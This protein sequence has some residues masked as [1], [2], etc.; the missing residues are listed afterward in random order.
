MALTR[1]S[2]QNVILAITIAEVPRVTRLVRSLGLSLREQPFVEAARAAGTRNWRILLASHPAQHDRAAD[3]PGDLYLRVRHH[4]RSDPELS[5][6]RYP[7][8]D[9]QAGA[10]SSPKGR[11]VFLVAAYII[12]IPSVFLSITVLAINLFGDGLRDALDPAVGARPVTVV[13]TDSAHSTTAA[14]SGTGGRADPR[15]RRSEDLLLHPRRRRAC[16]RRRLLFAPSAGETL[17]VVGES[18]CGKSIT[19][20]SVL[21]LIQ[22]PPGRIVGGKIRFKGRNLLDLSEAEMRVSARQSDL[23]DLSGADDIAQSGADDRAPDHGDPDAAS[24]AVSTG[25]AC[26]C[27]RDACRLCAFPRR[28]GA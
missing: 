1:A 21:R 6:R 7:A 19:A 22:S 28:S 23:D 12:L 16:G 24:G 25:R 4:H 5:R 8:H 14:R 15:D 27:R 13:T 10:T 17:G 9:R 20:L 3:R 18:G 11:M 26:A 2:I